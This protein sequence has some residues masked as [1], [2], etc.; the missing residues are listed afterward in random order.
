LPADRTIT[1]IAFFARR[2]AKGTAHLLIRFALKWS[3]GSTSVRLLGTRNSNISL[4]IRTIW[5]ANAASYIMEVGFAF[6]IPNGTPLLASKFWVFA[7]TFIFIPD[8]VA[9]ATT[10]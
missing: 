2:V 3:T 6:G 8:C 10:I 4:A 1:F 7:F 9:D 5:G